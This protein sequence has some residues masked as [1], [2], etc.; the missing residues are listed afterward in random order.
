MPSEPGEEDASAGGEFGILCLESLQLGLRILGLQATED[1]LLCGV[2][3]G[4]F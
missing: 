1:Q 3:D 2:G 4:L